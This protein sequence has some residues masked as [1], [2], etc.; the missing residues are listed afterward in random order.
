MQM[1]KEERSFLLLNKHA[2]K[3]DWLLTM[4]EIAKV[5]IRAQL[6]VLSTCH[7]S[8]GKVLTAEGV[9]GIARAFLGCGAR[10]VLVTLWAI[11]D[12][13][14]LAFMTRFYRKLIV[15]NMSASRALQQSMKEMRDSTEYSDVKYWAPFVLYGDDVTLDVNAI[16]D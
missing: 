5:S 13:S 6:V 16:R 2:E 10:S 4:D 14:T 1:Q 9:V 8:R 3:E 12:T 15:H 7:S 11:D